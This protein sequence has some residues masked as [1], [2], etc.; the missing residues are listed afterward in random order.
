M[1][2]VLDINNSKCDV[3]LSGSNKTELRAWKNEEQIEIMECLRVFCV[4]SF[5]LQ[6]YIQ[7]YKD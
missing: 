2:K 1:G 3:L 5:V 6:F 4:E 7:K